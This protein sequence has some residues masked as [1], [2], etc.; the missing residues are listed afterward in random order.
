E[1]SLN[2]I[3][4][5]AFVAVDHP[6]RT[7]ISLAVFFRHVGLVDDEL[8]PRLREL[9]TTRML[10]RARVLGAALRVAYLVSASTTGVLPKTPMLVE[11]G[12]LVLRF[13][14][15]TKPRGGGR[16]FARLRQLARLIG[17]EPVMEVG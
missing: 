3:A 17:R 12:R 1:Q 13:A 2:I 7:F 15:A 6:G 4:N 8:S 5:A 14:N 9:A 11:K 16:V 10:D